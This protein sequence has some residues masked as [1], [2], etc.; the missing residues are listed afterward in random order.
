[1]KGLVLIALVQGI[2]LCLVGCRSETPPAQPDERA[3]NAAAVP[4]AT[5]S[6]VEA[7]AHA[8]GDTVAVATGVST[9]STAAGR[10]PSSIA[11]RFE[12]DARDSLAVEQMWQIFNDP[13]VR[14]PAMDTVLF[15]LTEAKGVPLVDLPVVARNQHAYLSN[16]GL[17]HDAD[18]L[19]AVQTY[20]ILLDA[21]NR[22]VHRADDLRRVADLVKDGRSLFIDVDADLPAGMKA[23]YSWQSNTMEVREMDIRRLFLRSQIVHEAVHAA[24]DLNPRESPLPE[25]QDDVMY[26]YETEMN[27][28]LTESEYRH[29]YGNR[30]DDVD[31][32]ERNSIQELSDDYVALRAAAEAGTSDLNL[33]LRGIKREII[34]VYD[35]NYRRIYGSD[36]DFPNWKKRAD[37]V[38]IRA[39]IAAEPHAG[40]PP[41]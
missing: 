38:A 14:G 9:D 37:G 29:S 30:L 6:R 7:E 23:G 36:F 32:Y 15:T 1:M 27:A 17:L 11:L 34:D 22:G 35:R 26:A 4:S 13:D 40:R 16:D 18:R 33:A 2:G 31:R 5:P 20:I 24:D 19:G 39:R 25:D 10:E 28:Y 8:V 21:A 12:L 3:A 41:R